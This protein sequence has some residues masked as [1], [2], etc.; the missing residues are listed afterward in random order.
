MRD[1]KSVEI[2]PTRFHDHRLEWEG[3]T[4]GDS[5]H[6]TGRQGEFAFRSVV[7]KP[8]EPDAVDYVEVIGRKKVQY[9]AFPPEKIILPTEKELARDRERR[10]VA[11]THS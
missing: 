9:H 10:A 5:V 8:G 1:R 7:M 3:I 6:V 2:D 11:G 4:V